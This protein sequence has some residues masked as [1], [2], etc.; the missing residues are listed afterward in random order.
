MAVEPIQIL[1]TIVLPGQK[2]Q[3][4]MEVAKLH[5]SSSV[6]IPIIVNHSKKEGPVLLLLAGVHGDEINGIE[7]VR[8]IIRKG[9]NKPSAGTII[10]VPVLNIFGFL[11]QSRELPDG[12]DL[13]R[14]FPGSFNGSLAGQ[15]AYAFMKNIVPHVDYILDFHTGAAQ[16]HNYPQVR[17]ASNNKKAFEL[18]KVFDAPFIK[19]SKLIPKSLREAVSKKNK[20]IILFEG[21]KA[22]RIDDFVVAEGIRGVLRIMNHLGIAS[23]EIEEARNSKII[24]ESKWMRSPASGMFRTEVFNGSHVEKGTILGYVSDPFGKVEKKVKAPQSGYVFCVNQAPIVN[25]GDA[26]FHIGW[27]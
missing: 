27:E 12:R 21:G 6:K 2:V 26:I 14:C 8:Q 15:F 25:K 7:I 10:C 5:T 4:D 11:T 22:N 23:H 16:R 1:D 18:A 13:N 24:V 19:T 3:I 17:C 9:L 20:H